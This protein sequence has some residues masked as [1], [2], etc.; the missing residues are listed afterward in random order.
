[1][2]AN[3]KTATTTS[4]GAAGGA[5]NRPDSSASSAAHDP[6]GG[7]QDFRQDPIDPLTARDKPGAVTEL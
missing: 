1:M 5:T 7:Y 2:S 6:T 3:V 4:T